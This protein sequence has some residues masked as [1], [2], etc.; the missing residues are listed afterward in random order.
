MMDQKSG[1][2]IGR[3][4]RHSKNPTIIDISNNTDIQEMHDHCRARLKHM[5]GIMNE[6]QKDIGDVK[7]FESNNVKNQ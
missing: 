4:F 2:I 5:A 3:I 1:Q 6:I 7:L